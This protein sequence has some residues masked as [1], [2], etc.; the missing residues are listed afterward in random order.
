MSR[1]VPLLRRYDD[2]ETSRDPQVRA[3]V[4]RL[5]DLDYAPAPRAEFR[6]ELR[7]Q[8]V[9]IAARVLDETAAEGATEGA[10]AATPRSAERA[11]R[12][13]R[14]FVRPLGI[15]TAC[16][17]VLAVGFGG[18]V[19]KSQS[20]LPGDSLYG[21]K[22]AS[23]DV[24]LSLTSGDT[25][26]GDQYLHLATTRVNEAH[27]LLG[28]DS[29]LGAGS[30]V[31]A[32][33]VSPHTVSLIR[34]TLRSANQDVRSGAELL[35]SQALAA[36]SPQ[37]LSI[38]TNWAPGQLKSLRLLAEA[39]NDS[40][41]QAAAMHSV[42]LVQQAVRRTDALSQTVGR[43]CGASSGSCSHSG[44]TT[45]APS[46]TVP[47]TTTPTSS[48]APHLPSATRTR[49]TGARATHSRSGSSTTAPPRPSK[50][51][52]GGA[53]TSPI[54]TEPKLSLPVPGLSSHHHKSGSKKHI[55]P[56]TV[57]SCGASVSIGPIGVGVNTCPTGH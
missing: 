18:V 7:E 38:L 15:A 3:V 1:T 26:R 48:S 41:A 44:S 40:S 34:S 25:H 14:R 53:T 50:T 35:R 6:A 56:I 20:A 52:S 5:A 2:P 42:N 51:H 49:S 33:G 11:D 47:S 22:R 10:V 8:L 45:A 54:P 19:W 4:E 17:A 30:G 55:S 43:H 24:R 9:A 13:R 32:G 46:T 37:P 23:E 31:L 29:A 39:V 57:T 12:P 28:H 27:Q 21:L 36:H 16:V